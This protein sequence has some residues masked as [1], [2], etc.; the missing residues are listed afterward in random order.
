MSNFSF[1]SVANF[2]LGSKIAF[3]HHSK[4]KAKPIPQNSII[5]DTYYRPITDKRSYIREWRFEKSSQN[6]HKFGDKNGSLSHRP[7]LCLYLHL[8]QGHIQWVLSIEIRLVQMPQKCFLIW[9]YYVGCLWPHS[10]F[11]HIAKKQFFDQIWCFLQ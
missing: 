7:F 9:N 4:L 2:I 1:I 3:L 11:W 5:A 8:P 6:L 10:W